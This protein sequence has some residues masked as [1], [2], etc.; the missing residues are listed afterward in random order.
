MLI[1][2]GWISKTTFKQG[3]NMPIENGQLPDNARTRMDLDY[4][5]G[6]IGMDK[7][8]FELKKRELRGYLGQLTT[9]YL[10]KTIAREY[11]E[12]LLSDEQFLELSK[13]VKHETKLLEIG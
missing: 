10:H 7:K 8:K 5:K 12:G 3:V 1:M 4:M 6:K 11:E 2:R 9:E 13:I